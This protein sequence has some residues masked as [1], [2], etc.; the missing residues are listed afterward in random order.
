MGGYPADPKCNDMFPYKREAEG[1]ITH[2][3]THTGKGDE[4]TEAEN[5]HDA[6]ARQRMGWV[7]TVLSQSLQREHNPASTLLP[8]QWS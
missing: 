7:R 8:A 4:K 1:D 5:W 2:T 3:H 6:T